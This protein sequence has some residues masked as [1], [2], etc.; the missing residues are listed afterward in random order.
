MP[1]VFDLMTCD[2][3]TFDESS[4]RL[5]LAPRA[6]AERLLEPL[7]MLRQERLE[8]RR[9]EVLAGHH[10]ELQQLNAVVAVALDRHLAAELLE[11][12]GLGLAGASDEPHLHRVAVLR[13]DARPE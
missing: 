12:G 8:L 10:P 2:F 3:Q 1:A 4:P 7:Q 5:L 6:V 9:V 11:L 13:P